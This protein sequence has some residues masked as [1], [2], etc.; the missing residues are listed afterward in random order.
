MDP[1][2]PTWI[3][4]VIITTYRI[5]NR[6]YTFLITATNP[7]VAISIPFGSQFQ[8]KEQKCMFAWKE[9]RENWAMRELNVIVVGRILQK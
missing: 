3:S 8:Q 1:S 6:T 4:I 5:I 7:V 9:S 2:L